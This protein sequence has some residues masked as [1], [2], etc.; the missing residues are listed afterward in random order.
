MYI[1]VIHRAFEDTPYTA[2]V[3]D[4]PTDNP[5]EACEYA[6]RWTQNIMDSWSM[7]GEAD[8][9]NRVEVVK[10][11][12]TDASGKQ[13]GHRSTSM[14]DH[15]QAMGKTYEVASIGFREVEPK[16]VDFA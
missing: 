7:K 12:H 9:N 11:L 4:C 14:G 2:A 8:G 15:M 5:M 16:E 3:V 1:K 6:Y 13:W 10:A